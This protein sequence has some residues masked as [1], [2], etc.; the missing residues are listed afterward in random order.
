MVAI[1]LIGLLLGATVG[2]RFTL[3]VV[4]PTVILTWLF[5]TGVGAYELSGK[6]ILLNAA[7]FWG[8][9]QLGRL[10]GTAARSLL[11]RAPN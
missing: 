6:A 10:G 3:L 1:T 5:D 8:A 4:V 9:L 11:L 7:L 2:F